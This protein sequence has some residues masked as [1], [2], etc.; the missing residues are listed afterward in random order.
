MDTS[1]KEHRKNIFTIVILLTFGTIL[2]TFFVI[3]T[4]LNRYLSRPLENLQK[5]MVLLEQGDFQQSSLVKQK[6]EIQTIIDT[7]NKLA[8]SLQERDNKITRKTEA[9]E[10]EMLERKKEEERYK[11]TIESSIDGFWMVDTKGDFH[12]VNEAYCNMIGY[13]RNELLNM[14]ILDID[15]VEQPEETKK[16]IEKIIKTGSDRFESKHKHKKGHIIDVE[17]SI[18]Y[19]QDNNK[20]FFV[21]LRDITERKQFESQLQQSQKMESIGILAG[22]IAH[23]F[24]NILF[25]IVGY[26]E[27]LIEDVSKESPFRAS[28]EQIYIGA[29]RA[30]ELVKQILTFSRQG[31]NE[32]KL[33]KMQPI[34]K[35]AL[36]L[37]RSTIS[38][39]IEIT[40]NIQT[41]CGMIKA[42]P[43]QI[44]Q[45]I[46]NLAT[47]AY[48][49][50]EE[51]GGEL[52]ISLKEIALSEHEVIISDMA[53]GIYACLTIVDTGKGMNKELIGKIFD[54]FFTT[55]EKGKGTGMGLSVVHGMVKNMGS[56]IQVYSEPG[57]G[58]EWKFP[59]HRARPHWMRPF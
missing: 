23:D 56:T 31:T 50:M 57:K 25:P 8:S 59:L 18:T 48:H 2:G 51:T 52:K 21:F 55:K 41:D 46:M 38:T 47:N 44:H 20:M 17:I 6:I 28:L 49:A 3:N 40:Q 30:S 12:E 53:S 27:M 35:E 29:T 36:K 34:I 14:S 13:S 32:L 11:K 22:G 1:W 42:D 9:L 7:F 10:I 54:P 24:N 19:S 15:V 37:I 4:L 58:T 43:T 45:I 16:R 5:N 33:M 39:T 26:T